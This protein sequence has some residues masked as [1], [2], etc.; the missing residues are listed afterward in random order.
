MLTG[1]AAS[2]RSHASSPESIAQHEVLTLSLV[3]ILRNLLDLRYCQSHL[4]Q[5]P[6][7]F[8][9]ALRDGIDASSVDEVESLR[10]DYGSGVRVYLR[11]RHS[12]DLRCSRLR[13]PPRIECLKVRHSLCLLN[14]QL[15]RIV[16][17]AQV[18][19]M[20]SFN[21]TKIPWTRQS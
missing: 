20:G 17:S 7:P 10:I 6:H 11:V 21:M 3:K 9:T 16:P 4:V 5:H 15:V 18:V 8:G 2:K 14:C 12:S 1:G 13:G 19:L